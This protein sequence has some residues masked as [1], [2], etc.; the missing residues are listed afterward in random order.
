LEIA[1]GL[2][3]DAVKVARLFRVLKRGADEKVGLP[4][5]GTL[6]AATPPLKY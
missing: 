4:G 3:V 1:A 6:V 2:E 5:V